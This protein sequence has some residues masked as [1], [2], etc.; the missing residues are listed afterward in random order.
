MPGSFSLEDVVGDPK[1]DHTVQNIIVLGLL[2]DDEK[3]EAMGAM[4]VITESKLDPKSGNWTLE[5]WGFET[6]IYG[7]VAD[8]G[9]GTVVKTPDGKVVSTSH[10][11][12]DP[13]DPKIKTRFDAMLKHWAERKPKGA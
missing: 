4:L 7:Q 9:Q 10:A 1:A 8:I 2:N 11:T 13:A 12:I 3:F 5:Q 6:D